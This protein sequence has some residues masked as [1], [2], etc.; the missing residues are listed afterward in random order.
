MALIP[1]TPATPTSTIIPNQ[2]QEPLFHF[3]L[4]SLSIMTDNSPSSP[5]VADYSCNAGSIRID[6]RSLFGRSVLFL[7]K[8]ERDSL[9]ENLK[10]EG[11]FDFLTAMAFSIKKENLEDT[12]PDKEMHVHSYEQFVKSLDQFVINFP[13]SPLVAYAQSILGFCYYY[14]IGVE[15]SPTMA[16]ECLKIPAGQGL[17]MAQFI[18][19]ACYFAG[20][21]VEKNEQEAVKWLTKAAHKG[22]REAQRQLGICYVNGSGIAKNLNMAVY[23]LNLAVEAGHTSAKLLL[24]SIN[25]QLANQQPVLMPSP[26]LPKKTSIA[27]SPNP[28]P[29]P[30][31][32]KITVRAGKVIVS[33]GLKFPPVS[34]L[35]PVPHQKKAQPS[36]KYP[37]V[38]VYPKAVSAPL[39]AP[40]KAIPQPLVNSQ[41][42]QQEI[43]SLKKQLQESKNQLEDS[44][45]LVATLVEQNS[46]L[47]KLLAERQVP[48]RSQEVVEPRSP[49]NEYPLPP[50]EDM[51]AIEDE[52]SMQEMSS[53]P[54]AWLEENAMEASD[55]SYEAPKTPLLDSMRSDSDYVDEPQAKRKSDGKNSSAKRVNTSK[56]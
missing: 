2:E 14:G 11:W 4:Y 25:K 1:K 30:M 39:M 33:A 49:Q 31:Q 54:Q 45:K 7:P 55:V 56:R 10:A 41:F 27:P 8:T 52:I 5:D 34:S 6:N 20:T 16:V 12:I 3:R 17:A 13:Q 36:P 28:H 26:S 50:V 9:P 19:G 35:P 40:P 23:W 46:A 37:T 22:H 51:P 24:D 48:E 15:K 44:K 43:E 38:K 21:G 42:L 53:I 47:I 29:A 32:P 18:L